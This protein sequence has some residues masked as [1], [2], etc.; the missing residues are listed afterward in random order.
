[1]ATLISFSRSPVID[2]AT[3]KSSRPETHCIDC[4]QRSSQ[5]P[6]CSGSIARDFTVRMPCTVST[7]SACRA[8]FGLIE[9]VESPAER[10][11]ESSDDDADERP[12][13]RAPASQLDAVERKA[14]E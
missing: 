14:P 3:P 12:Q 11:H 7:R 9:G 2:W 10:P 5:T 4:A 8:A 6:P 1:M 13:R